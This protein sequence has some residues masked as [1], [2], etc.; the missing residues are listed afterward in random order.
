MKGPHALCVTNQGDVPVLL[1]GCLPSPGV[2]KDTLGIS[3]LS[4]DL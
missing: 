3:G 1:R 2:V 4:F